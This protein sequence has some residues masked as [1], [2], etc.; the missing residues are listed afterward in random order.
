MQAQYPIV[1]GGTNAV[2]QQQQFNFQRYEQQN[3][4]YRQEIADLVLKNQKLG[5]EFREKTDQIQKTMEAKLALFL[6]I[7][8]NG[9][10]LGANLMASVEESDRL[11]A[12]LMQK[13]EYIAQLENRNDAMEKQKQ[14]DQQII[15]TLEQQI[16]EHEQTIRN[17]EN[18][19]NSLK[20][21][22][23]SQNQNAEYESNYSFGNSGFRFSKQKGFEDEIASH[24][25]NL[26]NIQTSHNSID[27]HN[28]SHGS[29]NSHNDSHE[30]HNSNDSNKLY[31][32]EALNQG[33]SLVSKSGVFKAIMQEDAN[34]VIYD[35]NKNPIWSSDSY[36]TQVSGPYHLRM[37]T[38]GNLVIYGLNNEVVW[39]S[40]T[41][42][43]GAGDSCLVLQ[44]E[45]RLI[46]KD[47]H[48]HEQWSS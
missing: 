45:G 21:A 23:N 5:N 47:K 35:Q 18:E 22:S 31:P 24:E 4:Q 46:I 27:S 33:E 25:D 28:D 32:D 29:H 3:Q 36:K 40:E 19:I 37:Q 30:S 16:S 6:P 41:D 10:D 2:S 1:G 26:R 20:S 14:H 34:F 42:Q 48:D 11:K 13:N 39:T 17:A 38:D 7:L 8:K 15:F 9:G 43:K 44:D 12:E